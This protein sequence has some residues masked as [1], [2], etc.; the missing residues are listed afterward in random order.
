MQYLPM[1]TALRLTNQEQVA[2]APPIVELLS[3]M[4]GITTLTALVAINPKDLA[5]SERI[6]Y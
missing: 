1:T 4:P 6:D 2:F 3:A 5:P